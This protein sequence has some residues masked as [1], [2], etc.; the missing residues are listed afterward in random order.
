MDKADY[1]SLVHRI[2]ARFH[3]DHPGLDGA[4]PEALE[5]DLR[6]LGRQVFAR[7]R[8]AAIWPRSGACAGNAASR[9]TSTGPCG[10][11][12]TAIATAWPRRRWPATWNGATAGARNCMAGR[13]A[14]TTRTT[15]RPCWTTRPS[16]AR[17]CA[18]SS[19]PTARTCSSPPTPGWR[20]P[21][22]PAS[23]PWMPTRWKRWTG[24]KAWTQPPRPRRAPAR[25]AG[26][27]GRR[28]PPAGPGRAAT[29]AWCE[30]RG[31]CRREHQASSQA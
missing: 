29:C 25:G 21:G 18:T 24:R 19:R 3:A 5:A 1:G 28:R 7:P 26:R 4:P 14:W 11:S 9:P 27:H 30:M 6:A 8:R 22:R 15:P 13:T 31:L 16:R 12:G 17:P 23:S 2:L 20:T 10:G